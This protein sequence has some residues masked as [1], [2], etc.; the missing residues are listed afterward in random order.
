MNDLLRQSILAAQTGNRSEARRLLTQVVADDPYSEQAW[1]WLSNIAETDRQREV[2]LE[3]VLAVDP[4]NTYAIAELRKLRAHRTRLLPPHSAQVIPVSPKTAKRNVSPLFYHIAIGALSFIAVI[5][6]ALCTLLLVYPLIAHG[7]ALVSPNYTPITVV[8]ADATL[9]G[10]YAPSPIPLCE[11]PG[12]IP[13]RG[14]WIPHDTRLEVYELRTESGA[15]F[16]RVAYR[17]K[18]GWVSSNLVRFSGNLPEPTPEPMPASALT[19]QFPMATPTV[20]PTPVPAPAGIPD[21]VAKDRMNILL[22]GIDKRPGKGGS[23]L[24]DA[25]ILV[26]IDPAGKTVGMLSIPRDLWVTIPGYG[27]NRINTAYSK[28]RSNGYPGG[29]SALVK[30]TVQ[31]NLGVSVHYYVCLDFEGFREFIDAIGGIDINVQREIRDDEYPDDNYGYDPLYIPAG[32]QHMNGDMA[33]KYTR[34]RHGTG[35]FDR[36]RRQR[37]VLLAVRDKALRLELLPRVPE[38]MTILADNVQTDLQ[39]HQIL[40]LTQLAIDI[41]Q[42][43]I[44]TVVID[45]SMTTAHRTETGASVLLPRYDKI[46]PL[47]NEMFIPGPG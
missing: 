26:T 29:G 39:L 1:L 16:F 38:L 2:C 33:L 20:A 5:G 28:G 19:T 23:W 8:W 34:T 32:P 37:E 6:F 41:D 44:K 45:G 35:D 47:I 14:V 21:G 11:R 31:Y 18:S 27:E 46:L 4:Q 25:I 24:T 12:V 17:G 22:L 43:N 3:N 30:E 15:H 7:M 13:A 40:A 42:N 9:G 10:R 36:S